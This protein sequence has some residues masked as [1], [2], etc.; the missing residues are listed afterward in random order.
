MIIRITNTDTITNYLR[1]FGYQRTVGSL[2]QFTVKLYRVSK[3]PYTYGTLS[4]EL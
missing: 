4:T 2:N 3:T 1:G